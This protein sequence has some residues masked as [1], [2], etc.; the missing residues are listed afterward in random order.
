MEL[1]PCEKCYT[2]LCLDGKWYHHDH[3]TDKAYVLNGGSSLLI[4][5]SKVPQTEDE[6]VSLLSDVTR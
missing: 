6:L 4:N 2:D 5:L 3:L 1:K